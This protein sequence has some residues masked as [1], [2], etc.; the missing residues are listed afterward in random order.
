MISDEM[1]DYDAGLLS[2]W[3]GG[4]V[5]WWQDYVRAE[6]ARANDFWRSQ[7]EA[8]APMIR[9]AGAW[10]APPPA[11]H[12]KRRTHQWQQSLQAWSRNCAPRPTPR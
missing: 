4:N 11:F 3:G 6:I 2:D 8:I 10:V 9:A 5:E 7:V 1:S 12:S